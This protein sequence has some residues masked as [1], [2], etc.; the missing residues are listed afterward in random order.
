MLNL[1]WVI[2]M[3]YRLFLILLAVLLP[4]GVAWTGPEEG[5]ERFALTEEQIAAS[6]S[7]ASHIGMETKMLSEQDAQ[8]AV[9]RIQLLEQEFERQGIALTEEEQ[10]Y[11]ENY[12]DEQMEVLEAM[13][14]KGGSEQENAQEVLALI[15]QY[16][17]ELG[18]SLPEYR[19]LVEQEI[20]FSIKYQKLLMQQYDGDSDLLENAIAAKM[21]EAAG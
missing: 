4:A 3:L 12:F 9:L 15:D 16:V 14:H 21:A 6:A 8:N 2:K 20:S 1:E 5:Q 10:E 19:M 17:S 13:L 11:A 18:I 7:F